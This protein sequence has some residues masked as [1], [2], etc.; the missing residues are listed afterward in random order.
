MNYERYLVHHGILGQKWGVRRYRNEDG[1][2]TEA[3]KAR[4]STDGK[5]LDPRKMSTKQLQEANNRL[6][7]EQNYNQLTG[8]KVTTSSTFTRDNAIKI[9]AAAA[10]AAGVT[11]LANSLSDGTA[12]T[13]QKLVKKVLLASG[14]AVIVAAGSIV[15]GSGGGKKK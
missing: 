7:M 1:T 9:G 11:L 5:R 8:R 10:T 12:A 13:G 14:S 15:G 4:Y 6:Q 3:G 2:L